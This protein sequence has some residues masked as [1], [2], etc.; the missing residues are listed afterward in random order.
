MSESITVK[1]FR[2]ITLILIAAFAIFPVFIILET[3]VKPLGDV[4]NTFQWIPRHI[5]LSPY[6]QIWTTIPL[7]H[8]SVGAPAPEPCGP[9]PPGL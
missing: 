8:Y 4:Q 1:W 9:R 5:T 7:L 3:T 2:R 6:V